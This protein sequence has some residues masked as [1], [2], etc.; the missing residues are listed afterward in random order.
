MRRALG[1]VR[2][3]INR[4][5]PLSP[6]RPLRII[7]LLPLGSE[8]SQAE[9][10]VKAPV[11]SAP[12]GLGA[13]IGGG[14]AAARVSVRSAPEGLGT[15]IGGGPAAARASVRSA[16]EGLGALI[17]GGPASQGRRASSG[18]A[19]QVCHVCPPPEP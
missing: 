14:P 8:Q 12:E 1:Q 10:A 13:L 4:K 19:A 17:G 7:L 5:A 2:G 18:G 11:R 15:L 3:D 16:P 9:M 6:A